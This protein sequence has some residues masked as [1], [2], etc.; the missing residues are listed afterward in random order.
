VV[1]AGAVAAGAVAAGGGGEDLG[2]LGVELADAVEERVSS[3]SPTF[4]PV[5]GPFPPLVVVRRRSLASLLTGVGKS[6]ASRRSASA[7]SLRRTASSASVA[8]SRAPLLAR[9]CRAR[10]CRP[11]VS[12]RPVWELVASMAAGVGKRLV[13]KKPRRSKL[14]IMRSRTPSL[15]SARAAR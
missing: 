4:R 9:W 6:G 3:A 2:P 12:A 7:R 15:P 10:L 8:C 5:A 1:F 14:A 13:P 11:W